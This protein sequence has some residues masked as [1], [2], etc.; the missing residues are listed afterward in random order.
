MTHGRDSAPTA[1]TAALQRKKMQK[2]KIMEKT[3][4]NIP[5]RRSEVEDLL[6]QRRNGCVCK[7]FRLN[8]AVGDE[9]DDVPGSKKRV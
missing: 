8:V 5:S 6:R 2:R 9:L 4:T 7:H 3:R 1:D